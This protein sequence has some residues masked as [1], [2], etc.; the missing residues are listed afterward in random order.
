MF[1]TTSVWSTPW[2]RSTTSPPLQPRHTAL[3]RRVLWWK[4][5]YPRSTI[6]VA[7]RDIA[8]VF[9]WI[10]IRHDDVGLFTTEFPRKTVGVK[11]SVVAIFMV[12][13]FGWLGSPGEYT[14][15][16]WA[17]V[18]AHQARAPEEPNWHSE[19]PFHSEFLMGDIML[20]DPLLGVRPWLSAAAVE[21]GAKLI[22]GVDTMNKEKKPEEGA[23][24]TEHFVWPSMRAAAP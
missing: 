4:A 10:W 20:I 2:G 13:S 11:G 14:A 21:H 23:C 5:R 8:E 12:L 7:R 6:L 16:R 24:A 19:I 1:I 17:I 18:E 3:A 22:F 15:F 9:R